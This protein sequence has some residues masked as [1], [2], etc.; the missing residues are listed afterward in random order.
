MKRKYIGTLA[1][2]GLAAFLLVPSPAFAQPTLGT[3]Q[4]FAVLGGS[5]VTNTGTSVIVGN[6]GVFSGTSVTGFPPGLVTGGTI[7]L[8]D[9]V[10]QQAQTDLTT[11]YNAVAGTACTVDLTGLDLGGMTLTS[12][13][14]CF[15]SSAQLTGPL[16]LNFQG[17]PAAVFLFQIGSTLTTASTSSVVLTNIGS[18]TCP[19]NLFW[20]IGDSAT[21]GTGTSFVGNVL[22]LNSI[23]LTTSALLNG[24]ALARN[25]AVTLDTNNVSI[26]ACAGGGGGTADIPALSPLLL[27]LLSVT[28]ATAAVLVLRR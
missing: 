24:R 15:S 23:T 28:L 26:A 5:T 1:I 3:A 18:T 14:Y 10:A 21:F 11:A 20:Q 8:A 22:A 16:T 27:L 19:T 4:S 6:V 25:G 17:N 12:G 7:H 9:G 2:I 13:V